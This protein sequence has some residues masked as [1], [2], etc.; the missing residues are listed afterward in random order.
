MKRGFGAKNKAK[1]PQP[2]TKQNKKANQQTS[3]MNAFQ[4][5]SFIFQASRSCEH[6]VLAG[7]K[8][9]KQ[10]VCGELK[11]KSWKMNTLKT[12]QTFI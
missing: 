5:W 1:K 2:I 12:Q 9:Q 7:Y 3:K 4:V 10:I 8:T 6:W 11:K